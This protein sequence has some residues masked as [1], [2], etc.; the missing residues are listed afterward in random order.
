MAGTVMTVIN[1]G[2]WCLQS[3]VQS[4]ML[5]PVWLVITVIF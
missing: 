1:T 3:V 2:V 4:A 5:S